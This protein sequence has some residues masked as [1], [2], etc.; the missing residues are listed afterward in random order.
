MRSPAKPR[1]FCF[2]LLVPPL[3]PLT[4]NSP[5]GVL[6]CRKYLVLRQHS[7]CACELCVT[8]RMSNFEST[9]L[10]HCAPLFASISQDYKAV[11]KQAQDRE[12][13]SLPKPSPASR[14][15][16]AAATGAHV[17]MTVTDG[18]SEHTALLQVCCGTCMDLD[19]SLCKQTAWS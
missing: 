17:A 18:T 5:R 12:A 10:T 6:R 1:V 7:A 15:A 11:Q 9:K 8:A 3:S 16:A 4:P 14:Q 13:A 19:G 2:S